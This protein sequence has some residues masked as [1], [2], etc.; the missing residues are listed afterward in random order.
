MVCMGHLVTPGEGATTGQDT[1]DQ[2][3]S[4]LPYSGPSKGPSQPG[5]HLDNPGC[6]W[7]TGRDSLPAPGDSPAQPDRPRD[8][9]TAKVKQ[10]GREQ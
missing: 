5:K 9:F 6:E 2:G 10:P 1:Q 7:D 3:N 8:K 4:S